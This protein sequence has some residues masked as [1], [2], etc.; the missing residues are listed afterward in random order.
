MELTFWSHFN[1][2]PI[3]N[4][5]ASIWAVVQAQILGKREFDGNHTSAE[6]VCKEADSLPMFQRKQQQ[7]SRCPYSTV[8]LLA[9]FLG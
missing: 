4:L 9:R 7:G 1:N 3:H 6:L 2:F 8:T 5:T